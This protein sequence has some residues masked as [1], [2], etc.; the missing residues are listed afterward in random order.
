[1]GKQIA[2]SIYP[3]YTR[4]PRVGAEI[5]A[6]EGVSYC[7]E[8]QELFHGRDFG[9]VVRVDGDRFAIK[10]VRTG[11][12]STV[13]K[14]A[15]KRYFTTE[16]IGTAIDRISRYQEFQIVTKKL[17]NISDS[18]W[19]LDKDTDGDFRVDFNEFQKIFADELNTLKVTKRGL[20]EFFSLMDGNED[21]QLSILE[22]QDFKNTSQKPSRPDSWYYKF[23][24]IIGKIGNMT[25]E[26]FRAQNFAED[27]IINDGG[28]QYGGDVGDARIDAT[29]FERIF[30]REI[31]AGE[32][33]KDDIARVFTFFDGDN[34]GKLDLKEFREIGNEDYWQNRRYGSVSNFAPSNKPANTYE[35]AFDRTTY[36][37]VLQG[38]EEPLFDDR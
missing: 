20:Q 5:Y 7:Y 12:R 38:L 26:E 32:L 31:D 9:H 35:T 11:R 16:N 19:I 21:G 33:S 4:C 36:N 37:D 17:M 8:G 2:S 23:R 13:K 22:F 6:K 34:N 15:W 18:D 30:R 25:D 28:G 27:L 24:L 29:E 10:W 1:M 14:S 3:D